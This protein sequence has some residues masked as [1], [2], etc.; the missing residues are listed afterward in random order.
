MEG[1]CPWDGGDTAEVEDPGPKSLVYGV[2]EN[3]P[4]VKPCVGPVKLMG[5]VVS[6]WEAVLKAK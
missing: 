1:V 2:I 5:V 6:K 3:E 4:A